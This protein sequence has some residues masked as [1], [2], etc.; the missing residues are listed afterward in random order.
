[1]LRHSLFILPKLKESLI[2]SRLTALYV[3][4]LQIF[5]H[6]AQKLLA[7]RQYACTV[8]I[9]SD[10]KSDSISDAQDLISASLK[11]HKLLTAFLAI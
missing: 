3:I 9:Q 7:I 1:M 10:K 8:F 4:Y 6:I 11:M 5:R 2:K